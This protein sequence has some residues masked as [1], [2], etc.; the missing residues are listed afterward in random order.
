MP[1]N[2]EG[3]PPNID[4]QVFSLLAVL[5]GMA[6]ISDY[7][8]NE[9]NSIGN[10]FMLLGQ[11]IVTNAAQQSLIESRI[12]VRNININSREHK[13]GGSYYSNG[14]KSNQNTRPEIE[15]LLN[16]VEKLQQELNNLK[17]NQ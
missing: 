14:G 10:W 12:E 5:V 9:Q 11:F 8:V 6:I 7:S 13:S 15:F 1:G 3:F 2:I 4:P 17:K 16:A